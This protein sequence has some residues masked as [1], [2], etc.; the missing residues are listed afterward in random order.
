MCLGLPYP[1]PNDGDEM[2]RVRLDGRDELLELKKGLVRSWMKLV[3]VRF[4]AFDLMMFDAF[5]LGPNLIDPLPA[6]KHF[7][8]SFAKRTI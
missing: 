5:D 4:D 3:L 6:F 7:P 8:T 1:A 2:P